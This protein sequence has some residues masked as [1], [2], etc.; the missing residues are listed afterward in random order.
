MLK[1]HHSHRF[2]SKYISFSMQ[3]RVVLEYYLFAIKKCM[4][5]W[6]SPEQQNPL[7]SSRSIWRHT[8][9]G[10]LEENNIRA[11]K[12][13]MWT[14]NIPDDNNSEAQYKIFHGSKSWCTTQLGFDNIWVK[15]HCFKNACWKNSFVSLCVKV[16]FFFLK[17]T[18]R[19]CC[20]LRVPLNLL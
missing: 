18:F 5:E 17:N 16:P 2:Q 3:M 14:Y 11:K 7:Q 13:L 9:L 6:T 12:K 4:L 10:T 20:W 15:H 19:A 1:Y 8:L